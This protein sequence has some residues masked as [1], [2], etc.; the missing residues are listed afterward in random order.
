M[1]DLLSS[2]RRS[3]PPYRLSSG[4]LARRSLITSGAISQRIGRAE[5]LGL[6][7]RTTDPDDGRTV[8]VELTPAGHQLIE[9]TVDAIFAREQVLLA[10]LDDEDSHQ[11]AELLR[12]L[13]RHLRTKL[14]VD[15]W[16]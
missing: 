7:Q 15:D 10:G 4:E 13:L 14:Q 11:L 3:G 5:A 12:K 2:L 6:V 9:Q 16:P 8:Q 1:R